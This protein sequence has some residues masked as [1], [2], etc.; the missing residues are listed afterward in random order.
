M[1]LQKKL[2]LT[3]IFLGVLY[4]ASVVVAVVLILLGITDGMHWLQILLIVVITFIAGLFIHFFSRLHSQNTIVDSLRHENLYSLGKRTSFYN[5]YAFEQRAI[6]KRARAQVK[7]IPQYLI[8]FTAAPVA[9]TRM[10]E[11]SQELASLNFEIA[12]MVADLFYARKG[13]YD[14]RNYLFCFDKG[15]FI[16]YAF[17]REE[18]Q[19]VEII[20]EIRTRIYA[21]LEQKRY[22]IYVQPFFGVTNAIEGTLS[23]KIEEALFARTRSERNFEPFTAFDKSMMSDYSV[24]EIQEV[25]EA[26]EKGEFK[27][28]YQPKFSLG[29]REFIS[30]EALVRWESP[31]Y[32]LQFPARFMDRV[33][34]AG[35]THELDLYVFEHVLDDL[36]D[37]IKRGRRVLPVSINFSLY[38]FYSTDFLSSIESAITSR[39]IDPHLI[40]V[41]IVETTSQA[42]PFL[43]VSVIKKLRDFGVRVLMDDFGIGYSNIGNLRKIPFDAIKIDKSYVDGVVESEQAR[44]IVHSMCQLGRG[45][46]MEVIAEGVDSKEQV[47]I[48]KK[49]H[50]DTIQGFYYSK[51]LP[52]EDYDKFLLNNPFEGGKRR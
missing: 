49:L 30:S 45:L 31:V 22:H 37:T 32:G 6:G 39:G 18:S 1:T 46:G 52:K 9:Y 11:R 29:K 23:R 48:L 24:D 44:T 43:S 38:E 47:E 20:N 3:S 12:N 14:R 35:L 36:S 40:E 19:I 42:N 25:S 27:V 15:V 34:K 51:A 41:E 28:F 16:V 21:L 33:A 5:L 8:A 4:T 13:L 26:L 50:V 10:G 17:N 2:L 7:G